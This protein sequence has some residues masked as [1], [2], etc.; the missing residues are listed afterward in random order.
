MA[1]EGKLVAFV[2]AD[3]ASDVL[4]ATTATVEGAESA[5]IGRI[6]EE[7]LGVVVAR[8]GIGGTRVVDR[9]LG[10]QLPRICE[11]YKPR[12]G[13]FGAPTQVARAA[14]LGMTPRAIKG[15]GERGR[16]DP[17]HRVVV[18]RRGFPRT[19]HSA[20]FSVGAWLPVEAALERPCRR[21]TS[22]GHGRRPA[23]LPVAPTFTSTTC[24][25][26]DSRGPLPAVRAW[27]S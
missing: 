7:H 6:V 24:A 20:A 10:E 1:N 21:E 27:P 15:S 18:C 14:P 16:R 13:H 17:A 5:V 25:T 8:T 2:P 22:T 19:T 26:A 23:L 4:A 3:A 12:P 11:G 9:P